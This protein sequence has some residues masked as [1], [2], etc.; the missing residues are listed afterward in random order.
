[1]KNTMKKLASI[2]PSVFISVASSSN[3]SLASMLIYGSLVFLKTQE[4]YEFW[5]DVCH[6]LDK[7][8]EIARK[9]GK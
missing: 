7:Y 3:L 6:K 2:K 9:V 4:G 1:M 5:L 8:A